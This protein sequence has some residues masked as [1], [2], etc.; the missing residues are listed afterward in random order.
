MQYIEHMFYIYMEYTQR[1]SD[2]S[3]ILAV[4]VTISSYICYEFVTL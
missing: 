3:M 2:L 1:A 4:I